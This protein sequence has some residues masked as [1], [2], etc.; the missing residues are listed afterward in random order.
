M[1]MIVIGVPVGVEDT[2]Y[3]SSRYGHV[4]QIGFKLLGEGQSKDD[5]LELFEGGPGV[6]DAVYDAAKAGT[7]IK[8]EASPQV[9]PGKEGKKSW[10]K[11]FARRVVE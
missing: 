3:D 8:L 5:Y 2:S 4:D 11:M 6:K 10:V 7:P 9:I 1:S